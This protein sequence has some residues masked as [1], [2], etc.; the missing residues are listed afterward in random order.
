MTYQEYVDFYGTLWNKIGDIDYEFEFDWIGQDT[1]NNIA[2]FIS[3]N[4]GF[5]PAQVR[6]SLENYCKIMSFIDS[7]NYISTSKFIKNI[8]HDSFF[9]ECEDYCQKGLF[10]Y[11][12]NMSNDRFELIC[13]P[14]NPIEWKK[15]IQ[16]PKFKFS[17]GATLET[18]QLKTSL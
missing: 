9:K 15:E 6:Q 5:I 11:D 14:N 17:F 13:I 3:F 10:V 18:N 2:I 12:N 1:N 16:L 8:S 7:L 4:K